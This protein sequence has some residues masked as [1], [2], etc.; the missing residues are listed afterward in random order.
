MH[1]RIVKYVK[2][3]ELFECSPY[4]RVTWLLFV[5]PVF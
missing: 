2:N 1:M 3:C 5:I 4:E